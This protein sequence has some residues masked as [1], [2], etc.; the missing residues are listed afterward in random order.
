MITGVTGQDGSFLAES[1]L[2]K[3]YVV[4]GIARLKSAPREKY[5]ERL[6]DNPYFHLHYADMADGLA[7]L[8]ILNQ[9]QP[10]EVYNL[11]AQSHVHASFR[12]P[13]ITANVGGLGLLRIL[14]SVRSLGLSKKSRIYQASTSEL[15]GNVRESPQSEA[16]PFH[17]C[18]PYAVAKQYAFWI[19]RSYRKSY[20]LFVSN[21][22]LFNHESERRGK[23]FVTRKI[24]LAAARIAFGLQGKLRLGNLDALRDWGY[25][26]DYVESMWNMLQHTEPDD[27]VIATGKQHTVREFCVLAFHYAGIDLRFQGQGVDEKGIDVKTG[28]VVVEVSPEFFRPVEVESLVGDSSKAASVLGWNPAATSFETLVSVMVEH[29]LKCCREGEYG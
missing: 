6:C 10:D 13:E 23:E 7:L 28:R 29:D 16:T 19:A 1:L 9:T 22:I 14:E 5:V 17:P 8:D 4:H 20:G 3:G 24:T 2:E 25:A 26:K 11:A 27:F 18:S 12:M 21:G 15:F